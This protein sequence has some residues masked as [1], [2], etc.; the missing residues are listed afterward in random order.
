MT[1]QHQ[2]ISNY[3][4]IVFACVFNAEMVLK[5]IGLGNTYFLEPWNKFDMVIVVGTDLSFIISALGVGSEITAAISVIRS[6]RVMRMVRLIKTS[7]NVRL[8]FDTIMNILPQIT[9]VMTLIILLLY[10]F[11]ALSINL[12][13]TVMVP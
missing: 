1:T 5:L 4:N 9:N 7:A 13:A 11:A 12:F 10:I 3:S 6:V 8:I 2:Q